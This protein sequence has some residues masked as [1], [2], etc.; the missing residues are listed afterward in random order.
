MPVNTQNNRLWRLT[1]LDTGDTLEGQYEAGGLQETGAANYAEHVSLNRQTP[2]LMWLSGESDRTSFQGRLYQKDE[3]DATPEEQLRIMKSWLRYVAK[4]QRPPVLSFEVGD[5]HVGFV[6]CVLRTL[7]GVVYDRVT[8][9]GKMRG[10]TFTMTLQKYQE[11][12]LDPE[13]EPTGETRYARAKF[14]DYYELM[15]QKEYGLPLLGDRLR[16]RLPDQPNLSTGDVVKMPSIRVV[17][18]E[19]V[20][21]D[22]IP[23]KDSLGKQPSATK[24]LRASWFDKRNDPRISHVVKEA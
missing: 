10:C 23:L 11:Y 1:N 8:A 9:N 19:N 7:G 15:A 16:K 12:T 24:T 20:E 6:Q 14:A 3:T 22:S 2:I 5:G 4:E 13:N 18:K 17:R 21:P